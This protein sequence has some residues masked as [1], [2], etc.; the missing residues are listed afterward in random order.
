MAVHTSEV[1][2]INKAVA[3]ADWGISQA[4][5]VIIIGKREETTRIE[6]SI[7]GIIAIIV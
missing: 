2:T 6:V 4:K 5:R 7:A 3:N 1:H